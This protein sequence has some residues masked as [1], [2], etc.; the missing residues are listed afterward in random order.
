MDCLERKEGLLKV[1]KSRG[2][3]GGKIGAVIQVSGTIF[4]LGKSNQVQGFLHRTW[5]TQRLEEG[6]DRGG[7]SL[8]PKKKVCDSN[9]P[10]RPGTTRKQ[11]IIAVSCQTQRG[12]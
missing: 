6:K 12:L 3:K 10:Y 1:S 7:W 9:L 5:A 8:K 2:G 11:E 4:E